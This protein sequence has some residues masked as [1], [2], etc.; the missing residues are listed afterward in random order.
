MAR[1]LCF[2]LFLFGWFTSAYAQ[3]DTGLVEVLQ[4][5][6]IENMDRY[7]TVEL[8]GNNYFETFRID[9]PGQRIELYPNATTKVGLGLNYRFAY[10]SVGMAPRFLPGNGDDSIRG[11]TTSWSVGFNLIFKHFLA[12]NNVSKTQGYYLR[13]T[14]DFNPL[15]A[16]G[17]P[18]VQF[19]DLTHFTVNV[20][21]GYSFNPLFSLRHM[22]N[23]T[24]RQLKSAGTFMPIGVFRYYETYGGNNQSTHNIEWSLGGSYFYTWVI[25]SS[26][27][28]S[29]G[30]LA[31]AGMVHTQLTTQFPTGDE[32]TRQD[33]PLFRW[34]AR[35][36]LGW[37][38]PRFYAQAYAN[39]AGLEFNQAGTVVHNHDTRYFFYT[40][41]GYRIGLSKKFNDSVDRIQEKIPLL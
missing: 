26:F 41:I 28:L 25:R 6:Y 12:L 29:G 33:N 20:L 19:P 2:F 15:W 3:Q 9:Q 11:K 21:A 37:N 8:F 4:D 24:E 39:I 31:S 7:L 13:N 1:K 16:P 38:G 23:Q 40:S 10:V 35:M 32:V 5:G 18:Y 36:G 14:Q 30:A 34:D 27:Y 17:D 22:I